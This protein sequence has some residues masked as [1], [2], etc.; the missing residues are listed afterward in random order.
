MTSATDALPR[1]AAGAVLAIA[2]GYILH[3]GRPI[4]VPLV[5]GVFLAYIFMTITD[6]V[7]NAPVI[8]RFMPG[9]LAHIGALALIVA[10][11]WGLVL[12]V[13]S[14]IAQVERQMPLYREN[15]QIWVERISGWLKLEDVPTL[16][17]VFSRAVAAVDLG[18]VAGSTVGVVAA[19]IG[20]LLV[21][22][23][24][25]AFVLMERNATM[26]KLER[27][28]DT[29]DGARRIAAAISEIS[30]RIGRFLTLKAFVSA[31]VGVASW[32]V[33]R[34]IGIDYA[35]FW[36]VLIFVFNFIP[37]VGSFVAVMLPVALSLVQ[38]GTLGPFLM[39]LIG[40]TSVQVAVGNLLEPSLMGRS[41]NLSPVVILLS[42]ATWSA[43]WG[44]VGAFLCVPITVIMMIIFAEFEVT[45]PLA[46]LLSQDGRVEPESAEK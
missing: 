13:T 7:R 25:T 16:P 39:A 6:W 22:F 37:Y 44:L 21:I 24:Y 4:L 1:L 41:L 12:M 45:R 33:M 19:L 17:E 9:W 31:I 32:A 11:V 18:K 42:L 5:L 30:E 38:F 10:L 46:I 14:N 23:I 2:I 15:L 26:V 36:A 3:I 28:A 43:L 34:L 29:P 27:L 40:L 35:E 8:G 20:N